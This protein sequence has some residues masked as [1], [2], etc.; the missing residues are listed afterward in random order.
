M[1]IFKGSTAFLP[2]ASGAIVLNECKKQSYDLWQ[3][4][5]VKTLRE[6]SS[7]KLARF[8]KLMVVDDHR[9]SAI[10]NRDLVSG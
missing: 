3:E 10:N 9:R 7:T 5:L 2:E 6:L 4:R 1:K 8:L